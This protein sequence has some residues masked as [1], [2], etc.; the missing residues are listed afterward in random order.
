MPDWKLVP[1][2]LNV[3][4]EDPEAVTVMVPFGLEQEVELVWVA[5]TDMFTFVQGSVF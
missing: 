1:L 4:P 5:L 2:M 3:K